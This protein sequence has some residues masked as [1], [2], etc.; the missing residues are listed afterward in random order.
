MDSELLR[1]RFPDVNECASV[2]SPCANQTGH[3][4]V[5]ING[6][7]ICCDDDIDDE[8][9]I[10]EKGAFCAGGCGLHAVCYNQTCQCMEGFVGD[11]HTRCI[12]VNECESDNM[13]AG[14][15]EWCVN[16]MGGHLCCSSESQEPECQGMHVF[17]TH[18]GEVLL[19]YNSTHGDILVHE[20]KG[21]WRNES[22]K[23][24]P[25]TGESTSPVSEGSATPTGN[26]TNSKTSPSSAS[27]ATTVSPVG[28]TSAPDPESKSKQ[29]SASEASETKPTSASGATATSS[30]SAPPGVTV[31]ITMDKNDKTPMTPK[32][33]EVG[34]E[35]SFRPTE[36]RPT[37]ITVRPKTVV[38]QDGSGEEPSDSMI[39]KTRS[40]DKKL[41]ITVTTATD[42]PKAGSSVRPSSET[43]IK[44]TG[45]SGGI[46]SRVE[47]GVGGTGE[48][49]DSTTEATTTQEPAIDGDNVGLE[50]IHEG[51]PEITLP[52][53]E[54]G[55]EIGPVERTTATPGEPELV[56]EAEPDIDQEGV[57]GKP[58]KKSS[59]G[60]TTTTESTETVQSTSEAPTATTEEAEGSGET[61]S[62]TEQPDL[63]LTMKETTTEQPDLVLSIGTSRAENATKFST[64]TEIPS[65][66]TSAASTAT[67]EIDIDETTE[68]GVDK[69]DSKVDKEKTKATSSPEEPESTTPKV[70]S[71]KGPKASSTESSTTT[72]ST[73]TAGSEKST[74]TPSPN[75]TG[76]STADTTITPLPSTGL[77]KLFKTE[78]VKKVTETADGIPTT[79]AASSTKPVSERTNGTTAIT[80]G[81]PKDVGKPGVTG[82]PES[83]ETDQIEGSGTTGTPST[84]E[85]VLP[86][87]TQLPTKSTPK[88]SGAGKNKATTALPKDTTTLASSAL[89]EITPESSSSTTELPTKEMRKH[90][91][92][93]VINATSER[94]ETTTEKT[95]VVSNLTTLRPEDS[96]ISG[97]PDL[98]KVTHDGI[99]FTST[100][101]TESSVGTTTE[102]TTA[103]PGSTSSTTGLPKEENPGPL[104]GSGA[105]TTTPV[106][107]RAS[108]T[109]TAASGASS[110]TPSS[111]ASTIDEAGSGSSSNTTPAASGA[112]TTTPSA[113]SGAS[114][115]TPATS[116]IFTTDEAASRSSS[117]TV[118]PLAAGA[119]EDADMLETTTE[120]Q[121]TT[122]DLLAE[123]TSPGLTGSPSQ[124]LSANTLK[125]EVGSSTTPASSAAGSSSTTQTAVTQGSITHHPTAGATIIPEFPEEDENILVDGKPPT[126]TVAA[127]TSTPA[128]AASETSSSFSP[129]SSDSTPKDVASEG[130]PSTPKQHREPSVTEATEESD[131]TD[132]SWDEL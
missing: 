123:S 126:T 68:R 90:P 63:V 15:G 25:A 72:E 5:N 102:L 89:P 104:E 129:A 87:S 81:H 39:D 65:S 52:T 113:A 103:L 16:K 67:P 91:T 117:T 40:T 94:P 127:E 77:P 20:S 69:A 92:N 111:R 22:A 6:G 121:A 46:S 64:T 35:I 12:D 75:E 120:T 17:K 93:S 30:E 57:D 110:T 9:C 88:D 31:N 36:G 24:T 53:T 114:T 7:Y 11:P 49:T 96:G 29:K 14:V 47:G 125:L 74:L 45:E 56:T 99:S 27:G 19:E 51:R 44:E 41:I 28:S 21:T 109:T 105:S 43:I 26:A 86:S 55:L 37:G 95:L 98:S 2:D 54:L 61:S 32:E 58:P 122:K 66:T 128:G 101:A 84:T 107:S 119:T 4:C 23:S 100:A 18:D 70:T 73:T 83:G 116:G 8:R 13:C 10:N 34:L 38:D 59:K 80:D 97:S 33:N 106:A 130:L 79:T 108:T 131:A 3:R 85:G 112:S 48:P 42:V 118:P 124:P 62:T 60:V 1:I 50:I 132:V 71:T 76:Q 115:T 82:A 78:T